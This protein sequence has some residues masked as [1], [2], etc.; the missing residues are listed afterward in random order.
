LLRCRSPKRFAK[1]RLREKINLVDDEEAEYRKSRILVVKALEPM[2]IGMVMK[3]IHLVL[4][5]LRGNE[6]EAARDS[7]R[8]LNVL[9]KAAER[10][11]L[12]RNTF[13]GTN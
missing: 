9:R 11:T 4:M 1:R 13:I 7:T 5:V 2:R 12:E 10:V 6:E 8:N 3:D